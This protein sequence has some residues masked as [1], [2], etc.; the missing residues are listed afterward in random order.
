M[1]KKLFGNSMI[2]YYVSTVAYLAVAPHI[3]LGHQGNFERIVTLYST[4]SFLLWIVA[5]EFH[6]QV[7]QVKSVF[8]LG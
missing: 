6:Y 4:F 8:F 5:A 7:N 3:L 2:G 1:V